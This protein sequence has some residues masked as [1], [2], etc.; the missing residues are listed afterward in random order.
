MAKV[1]QPKEA[2][3]ITSDEERPE[4]DRYSKLVEHCLELYELFKK[5]TYRA[6]KITEIEEARKAYEQN[7]DNLNEPWPDAA[8]YTMPLTT[9]A[10]DNLEPRI[11]SGLIGVDPIVSFDVEG[12]KGPIV[13]ALQTFYN[14]ELKDII[15]IKD[16]GIAVSHTVLNEGT[17]FCAAKYSKDKKKVRDF[18]FD[19]NGR[20]V[21]DE[22]SQEAKIVDVEVTAFEGGK[23]D[24]I[25]FTD[26]YC[27]DDLGTQEDWERE[28]VI[29]MVRPTYAELVQKVGMLGYMNI[30]KHLLGDK[31]SRKID[32]ESQTPAQAIDGVEVTG[33][34]T[35]ESLECHLSYYLPL[36]R[37]DDQDEG[38]VFE[39]EKII[40]TIALKSQTIYRIIKQTDINF[41]NDKVVK[42]I[43][44]NPEAGRSF[45]TGIYGK[46]KSLQ[47]G[48]SDLFNQMINVATIIMIPYFFYEEKAGI[49]D[50]VVLSPGQGVPVDDVSGVKFPS[51]SIN[52]AGFMKFVE[53][54]ISLWERSTSISDAQIGRLADRK[55]TATGILTAV[56]EG[57]IK[58]NYQAEIFKEEFLACVSTMYDLYYKNMP[59]D[60]TIKL[61][62][63]DGNPVEVLFRR[64]MRHPFKFRLTGSTEKANKLIS[65]KESEDL[66]GMFRNDPY[67]DQV[68]L[69]KDVLKNY[70]KDDPDEYID[71]KVGQIQQAL[72]AFPQLIPMVLQ[73]AQKLA[74]G[75]KAEKGGAPVEQGMA[76]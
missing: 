52:P 34:E 44:L 71:P 75:P 50:D 36:D 35:I 16:F 59:Y 25:P 3:K 19:D 7:S 20:M 53:F 58:H 55:E 1:K 54:F 56:Q 65:R 5:S 14:K 21:M 46:I 27:A 4:Q 43:R 10:I 38:D 37:E 49:K 64:E 33:K 74:A 2:V 62:D 73:Q 29:R 48:C 67:V 18:V 61:P 39:E 70:G 51:V 47:N 8:N 63:K 13:E 26:I 57:G 40:V 41:N 66:L 76:A 6:A 68:K 31:G 60:K 72:S 30:G 22:E 24:Q 11:V 42:R 15:K 23:F 9:I 32:S 12:K 17:Y 28:P 45:G 69:R